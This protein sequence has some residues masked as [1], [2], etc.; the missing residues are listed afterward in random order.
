[1]TTQ[2]VTLMALARTTRKNDELVDI[3]NRERS[4]RRT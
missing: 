3:L 1:M 2:Q 4:A